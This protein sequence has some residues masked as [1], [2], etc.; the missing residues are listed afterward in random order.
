MIQTN[1]SGLGVVADGL[2]RLFVLAA[3]GRQ[4]TLRYARAGAWFGLATHFGAEPYQAAAVVNTTVIRFDHTTPALIS[5]RA[6]LAC[7]FA[8]EYSELSTYIARALEQA[9]FGTVKSRV[10]WH[11]LAL[12]GDGLNS[13]SVQEVCLTQQALADVVGTVRE[14]VTRVLRDFKALGLI[15]VRRSTIIVLDRKRLI[16]ESLSKRRP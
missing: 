10:A 2:L 7:E 15:A 13:D 4:V 5:G 3:D 6:D 16:R 8:R 11:L 9:L 12:T 14:V 1:Q